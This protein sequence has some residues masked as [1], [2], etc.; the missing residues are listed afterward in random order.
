MTASLGVHVGHSW[1]SGLPRY[2]YHKPLDHKHVYTGLHSYSLTQMAYFTAHQ[3]I[4]TIPVTAQ[5]SNGQATMLS[6]SEFC[7]MVRADGFDVLNRPSE[8]RLLI[9]P[10]FRDIIISRRSKWGRWPACCRLASLSMS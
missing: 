4:T 10:T 3:T 8:L 5:K 6:L 9:V 7:S 1:R 2:T